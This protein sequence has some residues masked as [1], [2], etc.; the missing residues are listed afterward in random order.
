MKNE[1]NILDGSQYMKIVKN[2]ILFDTQYN[3]GNSGCR[4]IL[5]RRRSCSGTIPWVK[6]KPQPVMTPPDTLIPMLIG[7]PVAVLW[8]NDV[9]LVRS[10][11]AAA[12]ISGI[13]HWSLYQVPQLEI[14]L[15]GVYPD[16][17]GVYPQCSAVYTAS[18]LQSEQ[19]S[20][21]VHCPCSVLYTAGC[22]VHWLYTPLT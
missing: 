11:Y 7:P 20:W 21:S 15:L 18:P 16:R 4:I 22:R 1:N 9:G 10:Q 8:P 2:S 17:S 3:I 14:I 19:C 12:Q 6:C 13:V 5:H